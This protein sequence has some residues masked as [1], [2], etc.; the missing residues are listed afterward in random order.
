ME[1]QNVSE[2]K[3]AIVLASLA[4]VEGVVL[5]HVPATP[6]QLSFPSPAVTHDDSRRHQNGH[7]RNGTRPAG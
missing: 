2:I 4:M 5:D 6:S 7:G 1:A 3:P